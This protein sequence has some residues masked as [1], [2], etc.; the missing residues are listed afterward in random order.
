MRAQVLTQPSHCIVIPSYNSGCLLESTLRAVLSLGVNVVLV[1]DGSTDGSDLFLETSRLN[2]NPLLQVIRF[3]ENRGKGAAAIAGMHAAEAHG[4]THAVFFDSD[5]QHAVG[6]IPEMVRISTAHPRSMILGT[7]IFGADAPR[8]R[9]Y[10]RRVANWFTNLSARGTF[11][12]DSLFGFRVYPIQDALAT[13]KD[14]TRGRAYDFETEVAVRLTWR[15]VRA[16]NFSTRVTYPES[17]KGGVSH[18]HYVRDNL[19]LVRTHAGLLLDA[20]L[21]RL[22]PERQARKVGE[23]MNRQVPSCPA[24]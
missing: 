12:A 1:T 17:D 23:E 5:G 14:T 13:L 3:P 4:F 22:H 7:P 8:E 24:T 20:F 18:F 11:I 9:V 19:L 6:D 16:I 15:G 21:S 10:A 2:S